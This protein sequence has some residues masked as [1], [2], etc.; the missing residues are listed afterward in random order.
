MRLLE[1][2]LAVTLLAGCA[3]GGTETS[4]SVATP[5]RMTADGRRDLDLAEGYLAMNQLEKAADWAAKALASDPNSAD[6][7]ALLGMI[8]SRNG[9]SKRAGAEFE[10]ALKLAPNSGPIL[11]AHA[12]WLCERGQAEQADQEFARALQ[13]PSYLRPLQALSNAGKC[14]LG[15]GQL[16]KAEGYFR[17][18]LAIAPQDRSLLFLMADTEFRQGKIM[19]AQAFIQRRDDEESSAETLE[20]AARIEDAAGDRL[21]AARYRKRLQVEFPDYVP[22]GEGA[23]QP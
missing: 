18:A 21:A 14:A 15:A 5:Y 13:D 11:N 9:D 17:R 10:R 12:S 23:R 2:T 4:A 16:A 6:V 22:T 3:T 1:I 19:E 20:L 8:A 7:H